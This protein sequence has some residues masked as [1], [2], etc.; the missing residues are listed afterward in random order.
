MK[1]NYLNAE[2]GLV[3]NG[4]SHFVGIPVFHYQ[5]STIVDTTGAASMFDRLEAADAANY[6]MGLGTSGNGND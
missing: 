2:G 6:L 4:L 1:G 3:R 5:T